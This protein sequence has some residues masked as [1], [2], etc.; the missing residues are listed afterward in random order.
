[1]NTVYC[2]INKNNSQS[3]YVTVYF[4]MIYA[5]ISVSSEQDVVISVV[6]KLGGFVITNNVNE[7]TS[8][9]IC[10]EPRRTLNL[11][12]CLARGIWLLSK[13]WVRI[14]YSFFFHCCCCDRHCSCH[15]LHAKT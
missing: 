14:S 1:M 12:Q 8:H 6:K 3:R 2:A 11:L 4:G 7:T 13:D 9:V 15:H 5:H 10:G